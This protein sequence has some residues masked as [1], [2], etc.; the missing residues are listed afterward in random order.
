[1]ARTD[2]HTYFVTRTTTLGVVLIMATFLYAC[3]SQPVSQ[4]GTDKPA[5]DLRVDST[6]QEKFDSAIV[7]LN[8]GDFDL[9]ISLLN[10]V[11]AAE[12]R[13]AA[14]YVN[15]GMAYARK[16]NNKQAEEYLRKAVDLDSGNPVAN[17]ELGMLYRKMGQF[18]NARHAYEKALAS[19]ADYL[20]A[21]KNLGIL[22]DIYL[23][24]TSCALK[25]YEQYLEYVP[26]D[27]T[28]SIWVA[29]IKRRVGQ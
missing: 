9:A 6:V 20:P 10:E 18:D 8:T 29:D 14:P 28:V 5:V 3:G 7:A 1:M 23:H 26:D 27:K 13:I 22:C 2:L 15:L 24:D 21:I 25:Q 11:I 4:S 17:N 16:G 12:K 19:H